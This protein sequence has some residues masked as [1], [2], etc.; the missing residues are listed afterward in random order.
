MAV[1]NA[2]G[3]GLLAVGLPR[4]SA[5]AR[6]YTHADLVPAHH[7]WNARKRP[8]VYVNLDLAQMGVGGDNSWGALPH[9]AYQLPARTY[10]YRFR[11]RAFSTAQDGPPQALARQGWQ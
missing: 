4:L 5:A 10:E 9:E 2:E 8:E 7:T 1:T 6:H 11:L 3:V